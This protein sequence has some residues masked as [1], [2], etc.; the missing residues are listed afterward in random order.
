MAARK[1]LKVFNLGLLS[2]Y[3][4]QSAIEYINKKI[5]DKKFCVATFDFWE[6]TGDI[7]L[8]VP[9]LCSFEFRYFQES[10]RSQGWHAE[11]IEIVFDNKTSLHCDFEENK[12]FITGNKMDIKK[13]CTLKQTTITTEKPTTTVVL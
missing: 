2:A 4:I 6:L 10:T 12:Y 9:F 7:P 1:A 5:D 11:Y 13:N 8:T 3:K